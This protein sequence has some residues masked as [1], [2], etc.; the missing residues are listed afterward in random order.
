MQIIV[1]E[2]VGSQE[3]QNQEGVIQIVE[4]LEEAARDARLTS[5]LHTF[6]KSKKN[7][8]VVFALYKEEALHVESLLRQRGWKVAAVHGGIMKTE[9]K[10]VVKSFKDGKCSILV[11][12]D[13]AVRG[14]VIPNVDYVINYSYPY[15]AEDY[16]VR[17]NQS[18]RTGRKGIVHTFFT[19]AYQARAQELVEVLTDAGQV[20]PDELLKMINPSNKKA[21]IGN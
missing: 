7:G 19:P 2:R 13:V 11:A 10:N 15:T 4:V 8:V 17:L 14:L 3:L 21:R 9:R 18:G 12:T 16:A 5:L 20:V 6:Q 1:E